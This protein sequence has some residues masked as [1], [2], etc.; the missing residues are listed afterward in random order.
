MFIPS[1]RDLPEFKEATDK[2]KFDKL[3][4]K[5][6]PQEEAYTVGRNWFLK[7]KEEFTHFVIL[8]DDL[9]VKQEDI[10]RLL[11][12]VVIS[13]WCIHGKSPI[14]RKGADSNLGLSLPSSP[15]NGGYYEYQFMPVEKIED[16]IQH[17]QSLIPIVFAGFAP[18]VIPRNIAE[19]IEFRTDNDCCVD[20]C[21][22]TDLWLR[23]ITQWVDLRVKTTELEAT[24]LNLLQVGKKA[25]RIIFE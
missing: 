20:T 17:G 18:T 15:V 3:W 21:L 4:V 7:H 14:E 23:G 2:L 12:D 25:R 19:L 5:Y 9:I 10:E 16:H 22:A 1:A 24:D 6:Y 8:P 11:K 13:G